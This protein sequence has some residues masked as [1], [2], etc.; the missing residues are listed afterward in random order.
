MPQRLVQVVGPH[1]VGLDLRR[2][3]ALAANGPPGA[4]RIMK[5]VTVMMM[6]SVGMAP[7]RRRN[8]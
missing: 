5:N 3:L 8:K 1:Q 7:P 2:Q 6:N 4:R